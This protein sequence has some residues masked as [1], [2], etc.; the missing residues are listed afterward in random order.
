MSSVKIDPT[1]PPG[2]VAKNYLVC[3]TESKKKDPKGP[4]CYFWLQGI[5]TPAQTQAASA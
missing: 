5:T 2:G 4:F 1:S 3:E